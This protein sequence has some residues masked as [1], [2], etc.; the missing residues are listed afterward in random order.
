M[1]NPKFNKM[2]DVYLE[3][4]NA[5]T[6]ILF[7]QTA[8]AIKK[9]ADAKLRRAGLSVIKLTVLQVLAA[10]EGRLTPSAIARWTLTE[11]HNITTLVDRLQKDGLVGVE[12]STKDGRSVQVT[13]TEKG[14][15]VLRQTRPLSIE[16][17]K[18]VMSSMSE[19][20]ILELEKTLRILRE[21]AYDE[22][23][24]VKGL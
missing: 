15:Q 22:L 17:V 11:R 20:S 9:Y 3:D 1:K 13:L 24:N 12:P 16:I 5:R 14:W 19:N 4:A 6:F 23:K 21:N 18:Q 10:H 2:V 7:I 8:D